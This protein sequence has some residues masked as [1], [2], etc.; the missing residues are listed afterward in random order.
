MILANAAEADI[1]AIRAIEQRPENEGKIGSWT[2]WEHAATMARPGVRYFVW[3]EGERLRA[4]AIF[5][6][7][8]DP[9]G[10]SAYLRRI[11]TDAPGA[12]DGTRFLTAA[13]DWLFAETNTQKLELRCRVGNPAERLYAR[14][15]FAVD[16]FLKNRPD[17]T[18]STVMSLLRSEWESQRA[19]RAGGA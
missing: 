8:D 19:N 12:G 15:G 16:G 18:S 11:A 17:A 5:E 3:R 14:L 2:A 9:R 13:L 7:L 6:R 10:Q 4:F 1:P